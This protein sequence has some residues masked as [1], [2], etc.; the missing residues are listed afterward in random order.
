MKILQAFFDVDIKIATRD[1][2]IFTSYAPRST[3]TSR[4]LHKRVNLERGKGIHVYVF[5]QGKGRMGGI[6]GKQF[7]Y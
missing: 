6:I 1:C 4:C 3:V 5:G 7:L 2:T